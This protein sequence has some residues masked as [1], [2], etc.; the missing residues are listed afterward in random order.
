MRGTATEPRGTAT[1][2]AVRILDAR[3]FAL[4]ATITAALMSL[5][6]GNRELAVEYAWAMTKIKGAVGHLELTAREGGK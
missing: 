5:M 2:A 4:H 6:S 3:A 1:E